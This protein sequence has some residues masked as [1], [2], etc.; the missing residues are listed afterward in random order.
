MG[1][2]DVPVPGA[3]GRSCGLGAEGWEGPDPP[4]G[5]GMAAMVGSGLEAAA[6]GG[7]AGRAHTGSGCGRPRSCGH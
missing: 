7:R 5:A 3:L 4:S 6:R 2:G 1:W